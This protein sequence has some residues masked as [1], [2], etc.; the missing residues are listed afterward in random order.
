MHDPHTYQ[1]VKN[2]PRRL[3]ATAILVLLFS[4][5]L[6]SVSSVAFAK[7]NEEAPGQIKK[8]ESASELAEAETED[9]ADEEDVELLR[10]ADSAETDATRDRSTSDEDKTDSKAKN[11]S[12]DDDDDDLVCNPQ[13]PSQ[14]NRFDEDPEPVKTEQASKGPT[15]VAYDQRDDDNPYD[16]DNCD[17]TIGLHGNGGNGKCAGCTGL[18]DDKW[19]GGQ[20]PGDHNNGYEC[21][22]N[23][24]IGKGNPAH[25]KCP[26]EEESRR[27][28]SRRPTRPSQ[29]APPVERPSVPNP[30]PPVKVKGRPPLVVSPAAIPGAPGQPALPVTGASDASIFMFIG[31]LFI[32]AGSLF[33]S[34][35]SIVRR[36]KR[37][38]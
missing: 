2:I 35:D 33:V 31:V 30:A 28:P 11:E 37:L 12:D 22:H 14:C 34:A 38:Y 9:E 32:G 10:F 15:C 23:G 16:H 7:G 1:E 29:P 24:G 21:D 36:L 27:R 25:S 13:K 6:T 20:Y 19:P 3:F 8:A 5:M 4:G 18:A 26:P 17:D